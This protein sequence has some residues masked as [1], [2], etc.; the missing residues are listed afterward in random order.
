M[1]KDFSTDS[2]YMDPRGNKGNTNTTESES[3]AQK[4]VTTN[5]EEENMNDTKKKKKYHFRT[6]HRGP[7]GPAKMKP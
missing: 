1:T 3:A 6:L 5:E 2:D 4:A 7:R